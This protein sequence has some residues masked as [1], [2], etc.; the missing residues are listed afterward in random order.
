MSRKI[1]HDS[2]TPA[3][4]QQVITACALIHHNF[5]GVIKVFL[6]KRANTK[7]FLPNFFE[8]PGGHISW[9][10]KIEEGLKREIMEEHKMRIKI[11]E[12]F[13]VFTY[14]NKI[15]G[16]HSVEIVYFA[17]F[18]DPI[19]NIKINPDDHS[20]FKWISQD[21]IENIGLISDEEL[22]IIKRGFSL[23]NEDKTLFC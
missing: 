14:L 16:S 17:I 23:L 10:E 8:L 11:G 19:E 21:E 2:E 13:A 12:P 7:K 4:G 18:K 6:A 22:K 9:G 3:H 1:L 15:K 5:D 20:E